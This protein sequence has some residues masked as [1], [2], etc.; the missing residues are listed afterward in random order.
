VIDVPSRWHSRDKHTT[1]QPV[2]VNALAWWKKFHDPQLN[3]LMTEALSNN[4]DLSMA[5]GNILADTSGV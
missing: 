3:Q 5:S 1:V 2:Q 4:N